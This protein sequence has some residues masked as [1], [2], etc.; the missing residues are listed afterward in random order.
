M[1]IDIV[2]VVLG[3]AGLF[4]GGNWLVKGASRL[5]SSFGVSSLVIGL[6]VV[7][8]GTSAPELMVSLN[9]ALQGYSDI[10][11][12]NVLGSNVANIGLILGLT[13]L[14]APIAV[15]W[16]LLRREIPLMIGACVAALIVSLD[17]SVSRIDGILLFAG[18]IAFNTYSYLA[19]RRD[20]QQI[21][22]E[23]EEFETYEHL[24]DP[25]NRWGELARLALG[26]IVLILG[27]R[28]LVDGAVSIARDLGVSEL[29][30]GITVVAIGTSLPELA[31][32]LVAA[33]R[34][35]SDIAIGNVVGSNVANILCILGLTAVA[36]PVGVEQSLIQF[37]FPVMIVF[38]VLLV[39]F[40]LN[41]RL[42]RWQA[43]LFLAGYIAFTVASVL[44]LR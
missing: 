33:L 2:W 6:T 21:T 39:P 29:I 40:S 28:F 34:K 12:G 22:P 36:Q 25:V 3:L 38:A 35:E 37:E 32:S 30:I 31:T 20:R 41:R 8:F 9:A 23:L 13:G 26:V 43:G 10:V 27:A 42:D 44:L 14:I 1:L 15:Q 4:F 5:A 18:F 7:A 19:A 16:K 17:G 24:I 11:I